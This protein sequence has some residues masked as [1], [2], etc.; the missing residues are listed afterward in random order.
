MQCTWA[1][2]ETISHYLQGG[3]EVFCCLLD[4]S[5]AFNKVNF[6]QLFQKLVERTIPAI[7]LWLV[8]FIYLNQVCFIRWNSV[9]SFSFK[10]RNG[11]R[12]GAILSPSLFC[13]Y[14]DTLF[15]QLR[16]AGIGCHLAGTYLGAYGYADDVTLLAPTR[17]G[18]QIM[19]N[20]CEKFAESRSSVQIL[21]PQKV[22]P[23]V[24]SPQDQ[25]LQIWFQM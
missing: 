13:V 5:K 20:I 8:L 11:V 6:E 16:D 22:K 24:C 21:I 7:V 18:L 25:D 10:V 12:Q 19:L 15:G 14:L 4:F 17:E 2:Q 3:S 9:E 23:S 1:V